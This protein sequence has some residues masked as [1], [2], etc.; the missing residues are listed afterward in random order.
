[1]RP[2]KD[3]EPRS[4]VIGTE[5][6]PAG[7]ASI[8]RGAPKSKLAPSARVVCV[9]DDV[10]ELAAEASQ[11]II[12]AERGWGTTAGA[13]PFPMGDL[14]S[15]ALGEGGG[16]GGLTPVVHW[17]SLSYFATGDAPSDAPCDASRDE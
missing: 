8:K 16:D 6:A 10:K 3:S 17:G 5:K 11:A 4:D 13:F 14:S 7:A 12:R 9:F 1:M 15:A 2:N